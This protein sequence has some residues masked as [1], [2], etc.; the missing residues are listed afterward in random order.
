M[1]CYVN[2]VV[3]GQSPKTSEL[4]E[5]FF[6][7]IL[8]FYEES[9][10]IIQI[11]GI[12]NCFLQNRKLVRRDIW[13]GVQNVVERIARVDAVTLLTNDVIRRLTSHF[14]KVRLAQA[15]V[16]LT[17]SVATAMT[18]SSSMTTTQDSSGPESPVFHVQPHLMSREREEEFLTKLSEVLV[19]GSSIRG[20][21]AHVVG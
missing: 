5:F 6:L 12:K 2:V 16:V 18:S 7:L 8:T 20:R 3:C 4:Q 11:D 17:T 15:R 13:S 10:K 9:K 19:R 1:V 14:E 21:S